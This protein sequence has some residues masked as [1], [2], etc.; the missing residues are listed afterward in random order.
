MSQVKTFRVPR[1]YDDISLR[2][3]GYSYDTPFVEVGKKVI[4]FNQADFEAVD[5]RVNSEDLATFFGIVDNFGIPRLT[6]TG[7][8]RN[9]LDNGRLNYL[10]MELS[11]VFGYP[12]WLSLP[13]ADW[14]KYEMRKENDR[15][16]TTQIS[17]SKE[18]Q[19]LP[20]NLKEFAATF[21]KFPAALKSIKYDIKGSDKDVTAQLNNSIV[22]FETLPDGAEYRKKIIP[23][24][25]QDNKN[26][27]SNSVEVKF[28]KPY[29]LGHL[30]Y[31]GINVLGNNNIDISAFN[32]AKAA[33]DLQIDLYFTAPT[34]LDLPFSKYPLFSE[35]PDLDYSAAGTVGLTLSYEPIA[36]SLEPKKLR[37]KRRK[38]TPQE[39]EVQQ[40]KQ[41]KAQPKVQ[42]KKI[43][44]EP[45]SNVFLPLCLFLFLFVVLYKMAKT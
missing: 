21:S 22:Y 15:W 43:Q 13:L 34:H 25:H 2:F 44:A 3:G 42:Q 16:T 24:N 14:I 29:N 31:F 30:S 17:N 39:I 19:V 4:P 27:N 23:Y 6:G 41:P 9:L 18:L 10:N 33:N 32:T 12:Q 7:R 1:L 5:R 40:K 28:K 35:C 20:D 36:K 26:P 45:K 11:S 37:K 8:G 38:Y